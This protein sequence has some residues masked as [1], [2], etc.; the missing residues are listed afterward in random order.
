[1]YLS[2]RLSRIRA[3]RGV[4]ARHCWVFSVFG[5][6][7]IVPILP[8]VSAGL[9]QTSAR[10]ICRQPFRWG[11]LFCRLAVL[12]Q[13]LL[14]F[15]FDAEG[16]GGRARPEFPQRMQ[17]AL[18]PGDQRPERPPLP[19]IRSRRS[20]VAPSPAG[21]RDATHIALAAA[22]FFAGCW[23]FKMGC[24]KFTDARAGRLSC[25]LEMAGNL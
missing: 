10:A 22:R 18:P 8:R 24:L 14:E 4:I 12:R 23:K 2:Y 7:G 11:E 20:R 3:T 15:L 1:M 6:A 16:I 9:D 25:G 21:R 13:R 19:P 17:I 5:V